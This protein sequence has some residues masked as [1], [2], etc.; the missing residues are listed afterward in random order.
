MQYFILSRASGPNWESLLSQFWLSGLID[1][2][3]ISQVAN[4]DRLNRVTTPERWH[5]CAPM[6]AFIHP[7][8]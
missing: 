6:F 1:Q 2:S 7:H 4:S 3:L 8:A 5:V